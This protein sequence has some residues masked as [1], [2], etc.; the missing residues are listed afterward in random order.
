MNT[1]TDEMTAM[2]TSEDVGSSE[3]SALG[4]ELLLADPEIHDRALE[5]VRVIARNIRARQRE[6]SLLAIPLFGS[7][8]PS[9][10]A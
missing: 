7:R 6:R 10:S 2:V 5:A 1:S 8:N 9:G 3:W 4:S